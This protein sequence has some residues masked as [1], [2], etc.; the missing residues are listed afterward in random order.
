MIYE[1][2]RSGIAM[3]ELIFAIT[4]IGI[5]MLSAPMLINRATSGAYVAMQQESV[6]AAATQINMIMTAEWD[7]MDTNVTR[8]EPVLRTVSAVFNQC[9]GVRDMP[10]GVTA[11]SG[12]YCKTLDGTNPPPFASSIQSDPGEGV[13]YFDDIDDYDG[14]ITTVSVYNNE[15]YPTYMGD[16]ID[17]NITLTTNVYYGDDAPK[18]ADGTPVSYAQTTYFSNPFQDTNASSTNIKLITVLLTTNNPAD[19]LSQKSIRLSAFMCNIGAPK[20]Q[21]VTNEGSL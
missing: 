16:Y 18:Q 4:V 3:I 11:A 17:Q 20:K 21:L 6:A 5:V 7:E 9:T 14:N 2:N 10:A 19:E 12:R 15:F 8:G 1:K 13:N